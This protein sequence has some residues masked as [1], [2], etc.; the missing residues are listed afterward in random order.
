MI[1]KISKKLLGI[2]LIIAMVF[3]LNLTIYAEIFQQK[4]LSMDRD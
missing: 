2:G 4:R 1:K 3:S